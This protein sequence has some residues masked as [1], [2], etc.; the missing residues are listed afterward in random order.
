MHYYAD[1]SSSVCKGKARIYSWLLV[2]CF[3]I[4]MYSVR[5]ERSNKSE[6]LLDVNGHPPKCHRNHR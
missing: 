5:E 3:W 6:E 2:A 4:L 1:S